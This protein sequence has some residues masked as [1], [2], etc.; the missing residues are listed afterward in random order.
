MK[1]KT[2]MNPLPDN[3]PLLAKTEVAETLFGLS[4]T[5]LWKLRRK[6]PDFKRLT[7]KTGREVL[8]DVPR[9]YDWFQAHLGGD[10]KI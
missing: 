9:C 3:A 2:T 4:R 8:Y 6:Y 1:T 10:L 7:I 5:T